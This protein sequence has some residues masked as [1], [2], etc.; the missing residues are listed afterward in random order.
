[1]KPAL[2][3]PG[4]AGADLHVPRV[5]AFVREVLAGREP[6]LIGGLRTVGVSVGGRA[7]GGWGERATCA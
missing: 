1:M 2:E 4:G 7:Q 5:L 3:A 6:E